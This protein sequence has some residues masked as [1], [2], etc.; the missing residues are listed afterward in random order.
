MRIGLGLGLCSGG[1]PAIFDPSTVAASA[2]TFV[3]DLWASDAATIT[4]AGSKVTSW[5]N[6]SANAFG[7]AATQ[8]T[9]SIR[10]VYAS[11]G[12]GGRPSLAFAT[13]PNLLMSMT[14]AASNYTIFITHS[15]VSATGAAQFLMDWETGRVIL[16]HL[17]ASV[18]NHIDYYDG[19]GF[20]DGGA[21]A[22]GAQVICYRLN[23][24]GGNSASIRRN[25]TVVA[26]GLAYTQRA[27]GGAGQ[28]IGQQYTGGGGAYNGSIARITIYAENLSDANVQAYERGVGAYYG[29]TVA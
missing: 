4:L 7:S 21:A 23:S 1:S 19:T 6:R 8:S 3:Q 9:D 13:G 28:R 2:L 12:I 14:H 27:L 25:G 16:S 29:I 5:A 11:S 24:T 22:T 17:S 10:P 15:P 18:A 26:S 20:R